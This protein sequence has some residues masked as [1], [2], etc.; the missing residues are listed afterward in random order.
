MRI[1]LDHRRC[2]GICGTNAAMT[3][4]FYTHLWPDSVGRTRAAVGK[5]YAG[6][7]AEAQPQVS[8]TA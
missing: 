5:A 8:E 4:N 2:G 3:L 1:L 7:S 6:R